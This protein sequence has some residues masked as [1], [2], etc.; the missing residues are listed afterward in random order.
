MIEIFWTPPAALGWF[1]RAGDWAADHGYPAIAAIVAGDGVI[2]LFPGETAVVAGGNF[3]EQGKLWLFGVIVAG[4]V[5]AIVGDNIAYWLGRAGGESIHRFFRRVAGSERV[6]AADRMVQDRGAV[7]VAAGRF[8]PGIRLAINLSCGAGNM[9]WKKFA[10][11]NALGAAV[12][13]AQAALLGYAFGTLFEEQK[14]LGLLVAIGIAVFIGGAVAMFE[15]RK[16]KRVN[17][18]IAADRDDTVRDEPALPIDG[19][20][21]P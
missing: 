5:G 12:W 11:F 16:V 15:H 7:L 8:L 4:F 18:A 9:S 10:T 20:E 14:W 1:D 21:Q 2:P 13:S 17:V 3:A 6:A 19:G